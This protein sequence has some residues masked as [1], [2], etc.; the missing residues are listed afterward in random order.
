MAP[1]SPGPVPSDDTAVE[2]DQCP[3]LKPSTQRVFRVPVRP[4]GN[5]HRLD[6]VQWFDQHA[7]DRDMPPHFLRTAEARHF[8][9]MLGLARF[10][11]LGIRLLV[12]EQ[13]PLDGGEQRRLPRTESEAYFVR[14]GPRSGEKHRHVMLRSEADL[15]S[16]VAPLAEKIA[17]HRISER[18]PL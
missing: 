7:H 18:G 13:R 4:I 17:H 2:L 9:Q 16:P 10:H 8:H 11:C 14:S 6:P 12:L 1:L 15:A 5:L 3:A